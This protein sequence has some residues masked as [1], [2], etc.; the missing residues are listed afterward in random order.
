M[1]IR[2]LVGVYAL[3]FLVLIV[4][5]LWMPY[6][7]WLDLTM[8]LT[9]MA[10]I[11]MTIGERLLIGLGAAVI[12]G[13]AFDLFSAVSGPGYMI[14]FVSAASACWLFSHKIVTTRSAVSFVSTVIVGTA[15]FTLI[16]IAVDSVLS[17]LNNQRIHLD[18]LTVAKGGMVQA[19]VHPIIL[20]IFWRVFGRHEY[21]RLPTSSA[22]SF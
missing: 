1:N 3:F 17:L 7:P 14:A 22:Q 2:R 10:V 18:L 5:I 21:H 13:T 20:S 9:L 16:L 19:I 4:D 11:V 8:N 6:I 12:A 15:S